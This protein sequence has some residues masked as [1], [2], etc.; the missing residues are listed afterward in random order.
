MSPQNQLESGNAITPVFDLVALLK[1]HVDCRGIPS[2]IRLQDFV[3]LADDEIRL[4]ARLRIARAAL[5]TESP[6][7]DLCL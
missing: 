7:N 1:L 4:G 6:M 2:K 5:K 3:V